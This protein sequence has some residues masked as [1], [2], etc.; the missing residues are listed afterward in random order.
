MRF[1]GISKDKHVVNWKEHSVL[2]MEVFKEL[3]RGYVVLGLIVAIVSRVCFHSL[4]APVPSF[5]FCESFWLNLGVYMNS[6]FVLLNSAFT[7]ALTAVL[8]WDRGA[9]LN[10]HIS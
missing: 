2:V 9:E 6:S 8:V 5:V 7:K 3:V 4:S 10:C 1:T